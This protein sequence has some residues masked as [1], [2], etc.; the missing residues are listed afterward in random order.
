MRLLIEILEKTREEVLKSVGKSAAGAA[1]VD[2]ALGAASGK[3]VIKEASC[4]AI[5]AASGVLAKEGFEHFIRSTGP[6]GL[7]AGV[8]ASVLTR[9]AFRRTFQDKEEISEE[10]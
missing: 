1:V 4:G 7:I 5:S 10:M 2:G 3:N 8:S 9:Y 6:G